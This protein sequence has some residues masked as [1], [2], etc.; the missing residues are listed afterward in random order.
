ML[1]FEVRF[2]N[3]V[4]MMAAA[5]REQCEGGRRRGEGGGGA[6]GGNGHKE[7]NKKCGSK[8]KFW[9]CLRDDHSDDATM[10]HQKDSVH[11]VGGGGVNVTSRTVRKKK[12][13]TEHYLLQEL[14]YKYA[15][16]RTGFGPGG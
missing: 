2:F 15:N 6:V 1:C 14:G 10:T 8:F 12:G 13:C 4:N 16:S 9:G 3:L 5:L 7:K 11:C